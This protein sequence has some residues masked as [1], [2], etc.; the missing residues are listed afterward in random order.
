MGAT[1][2]LP[3]L[4]AM[5]PASPRWP[6]RRRPR[7]ALRRRLHSARRHH[8]PLDAGQGGP[9]FEFTP[10]LKPLEP[11]K[12]HVVVVSNL[13]RARGTTTATPPRRPHG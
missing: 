12:D 5:V 1:V 7:D 4:D 2:A 8:G 11:F 9:G 10:I 6:R 13:D 3:L